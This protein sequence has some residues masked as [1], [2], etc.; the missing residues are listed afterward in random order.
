VRYDVVVVGAGAAGCAVAARLS[1]DERRRVL[2]LEAGP[3]YDELPPDVRSSWV[4]T[5]AHDWGFVAEPDA[6]GRRITLPRGKLVGGCS[7][8][9]A[10]IA[11]RGSPADYDG[12][13][14]DGWRFIDV[15]PFFRQLET[16]ADFDDEWHGRE[17]PL[18]VGRYGEDELTAVQRA[19]LEAALAAGHPP[20]GDHN[21]PGVVGMG[22]APM[23]Q[24]D[25]ARISAALAYV[26]PARTR[27]NL[28][29]QADGLVDRVLVGRGVVLANGET[30]DADEVVLTAGAY[31][32]PAI[33]MRSGIGP[34]DELKLHGIDCIANLPA[35]GGNLVD[36]PIVSFAFATTGERAAPRFQTILT[37]HSETADPAGAPD[38]QLIPVS[39]FEIE[40]EVW[41]FTLIASVLKPRSRGHVGLSSR[42]PRDPPRIT[43]GHLTHPE[44]VAR[45]AEALRELRRIALTE[46]LASLT[47]GRELDPPDDFDLDQTARAR[48]ETYHHPVGTCA[49]GTVVDV[50]GRV[51]GVKGIRLA[52]ASVMPDIPSA[53]THLPTLMV[54]EKVASLLRQSAR[55]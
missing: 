48:V 34:A 22:A 15:L 43:T 53:N 5:R 46:P 39:A 54:A 18:P 16:D 27:P 23:N 11:L 50:D 4:P 14:I 35:V 19:A 32:S 12:W 38:L 10:C 26:A 40:P 7:A 29:I 47:A 1:E 6:L 45:M 37:W 28:T 51:H 25:G 31:G 24:R 2:L 13:G 41:Q 9:N 44:D 42:D 49:L 55:R 3:D 33:L 17:G 20:A 21:R 30:I 52:D 8:T 36:H